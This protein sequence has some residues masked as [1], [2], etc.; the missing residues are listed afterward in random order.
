MKSM[1]RK[2]GRSDH[3]PEA[4]SSLLFLVPADFS[5]HLL[6]WYA[7]EKRDLPWRD[8][9]DPYLTWISEVMLQ[10]TRVDQAAPYFH[11]FIEAFPDV[12]ALAR[13]ELDQVLLNW[14]GLGYYSRARNLHRAARVVSEEHAG[15]LPRSRA[16]LRQLPGIGDYTSAAISSI[17]FGEREAVVDGNVIRVISRFFALDGDRKSGAL[18]RKVAQ[19]VDELVPEASP[20]D[21]NQA[22]MDLGAQICTPRDPQCPACP[23]A[24]MCLARASGNPEAYPEVTVRSKTPHFDVAVGIVISGD[25][26]LI[27]RR[28]EDA[29]LGGMWEFPGGK[30]EDGES[31]AAA[32]IREVGEETGLDIEIIDGL[33]EVRHA[34]SH[35]RVTLHP[36][37]ARIV[38]GDLAETPDRRWAGMSELDNFAFPTGSFRIIEHLRRTFITPDPGE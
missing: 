21:F 22:M 11:R 27:Q 8:V 26:I 12:H 14:A 23:V 28:A 36:F 10:Q 30:L 1:L 38:R 16:E 5:D 4:H 20:G 37:T 6:T 33:P 9:D 31:P 15:Y 18:R 35:F 24:G 17:A 34:Y 7:S 2:R 19:I 25:C 13:A 32:C 29:M 3:V